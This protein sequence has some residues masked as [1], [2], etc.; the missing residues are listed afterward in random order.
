MVQRGFKEMAKKS[1]MDAQFA[2]MNLRLSEHD[3]RF[4]K[5]EEKIDENRNLLDG[6]VKAQEDFKDEFAVVKNQASKIEKIEEV[7]KDKLGVKIK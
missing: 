5:L 6:Y 7:I 3:K 2:T 1:D 4:D